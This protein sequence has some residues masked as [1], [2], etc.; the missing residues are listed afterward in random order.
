MGTLSEE[1]EVAKGGTL[2]TNAKFNKETN[3]YKKPSH[4]GGGFSYGPWQI[5]TGTKNPT[6]QEYLDYA[7]DDNE[8]V[9]NVLNYYGGLDGAKN[10]T[11]EFI[12]N[13]WKSFGS[14]KEKE[15]EFR[16]S[17]FNFIKDKKYTPAIKYIER[18][19][20]SL[21][22]DNRDPVIKDVIWSMSV[23]HGRVNTI[24]R[25]A[26]RGKDLTK[27][28]DAQIID[29]LYDSRANYIEK[30]KNDE[31]KEINKNK[32]L[33]EQQKQRRI[34]NKINYW[35]GV[36]KARTQSERQDALKRLNNNKR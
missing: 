36:K 29:A 11:T 12:D 13:G 7:Q 17:Q 19:F 15:E 21:D 35:N 23:Q 22:I 6:F 8:W 20:S 34:K 2:A 24:T 9:A 33:S 14:H 4:D 5:E 10:G 28:N 31:I 25:N 30:V 3:E 32:N 18:N 1:Y 27:M 16:Q 26:L